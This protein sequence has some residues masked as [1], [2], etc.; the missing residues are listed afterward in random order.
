MS[1][2]VAARVTA[3]RGILQS[4]CDNLDEAMAELPEGGTD[5][6]V[7][8]PRLVALLLGVVQARRRLAGLER[9]L[10]DARLS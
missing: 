4:A 1:N 3:A 8:T 9:L 2:Q 7:A 6:T 10:A 5:D